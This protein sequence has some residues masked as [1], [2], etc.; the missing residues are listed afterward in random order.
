MSKGRQDW[1]DVHISG[2]ALF[3]AL[4]LL[5]FYL[6]APFYLLRFAALF[7]LLLLIGSR[8]YSEYLIRNIRLF[9]RDRDLRRFRGEWVQAELTVENHGRLPAF[10]LAAG[11]SPGD[12]AV[13]RQN[14][15][16]LSLRGRSRIFI[17]WQAYCSSRGIH[18]LGPAFIRG[19]DPLGLFP[20]RARARETSRLVVYPSPGQI[21]VKTPGGLPLGNMITGNPL[22]EDLTRRRSLREYRI[23][24]ELRRINW[25]ASAALTGAGRDTVILVNEYEAAIASPM[26]IFLN[27]DP[28]EYGLRK[29]EFYFER[30]IEGA[31]ALCLMANRDRQDLGIILYHPQGKTPLTL[32]P[33]QAR[34]L[35]PIL[36]RLAAITRPR[37]ASPEHSAPGLPRESVSPDM[38]PS[39]RIRMSVQMMLKEGKGLPYGT[40][41]FYVGPERS[42]E[43]YAVLD[44]LKRSHLFPEYLILDEK[45]LEESM[46]GNVRRYQMKEA[47]YAVI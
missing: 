43:E 33:P 38:Y 40:R 1:A 26:V 32:I 5:L 17:P 25:K 29:R 30:S 14:R 3:F 9:R 16:L 47:G 23:G 31:A 18:T 13:F 19:S 21:E 4:P 20:F 8:F 37:E 34:T 10:M 46:P 39:Q 6:F 22:Y 41:L 45:A 24:D 12:I 42:R 36:E 28:Y 44:N 7:L 27:L 35:I 2:T 11:D 15:S